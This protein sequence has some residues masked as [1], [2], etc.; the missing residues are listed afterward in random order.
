MSERVV[1]RLNSVWFEGVLKTTKA[2]GPPTLNPVRRARQFWQSHSLRLQLLDPV[3]F[4][5]NS[6]RFLGAN[7]A[8]PGAP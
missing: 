2:R 5:F 4:L 3:V 7:S 1:L 6:L 8:F